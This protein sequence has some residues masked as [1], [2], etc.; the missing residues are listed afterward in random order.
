VV[1]DVLID[2]GTFIGRFSLFSDCVS[3]MM[4]VPLTVDGCFPIDTA[5][6]PRI[7]ESTATLQ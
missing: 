1:A 3:L 4:N 5:S 2:Y 7:L 6:H